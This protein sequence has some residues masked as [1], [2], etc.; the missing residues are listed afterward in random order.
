MSRRRI[1]RRKE[2]PPK[3]CESCF[4][5]R[6]RTVVTVPWSPQTH[7]MYPKTLKTAA[8][9]LL[10]VGQ[11]PDNIFSKL[12]KD[13]WLI[14]MRHVLIPNYMGNCKISHQYCDICMKRLYRLPPC[15]YCQMNHQLASHVFPDITYEVVNKQF[16]PKE[17]RCS[18]CS[19]VLYTCEIHKSKP[20]LLLCYKCVNP[21]KITDAFTVSFWVN[22]PL[23]RPK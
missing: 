14:I 21:R 9:Y 10:M 5:S 17:A 15:L 11:H 6:T 2:E 13:I 1:P 16:K 20:P 4:K 22:L 12:G 19:A 8:L 18:R 23:I 7:W 3:T